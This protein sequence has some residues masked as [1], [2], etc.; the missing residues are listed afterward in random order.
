MSAQP[1][2]SLSTGNYTNI[3]RLASPRCPTRPCKQETLEN[4]MFRVMQ[5]ISGTD[6]IH[7]VFEHHEIVEVSRYRTHNYI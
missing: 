3:T 1:D 7:T 6:R 2:L 5:L 4:Y